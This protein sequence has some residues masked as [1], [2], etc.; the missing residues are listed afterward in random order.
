MD[1]HPIHIHGHAM[2]VVSTDGGEI[3]PSARFPETT[4]LVPVGT[5]RTIEFVADNPGDWPL[6]CH[7]THHAM[8]QMGHNVANMIGVDTHGLDA[9]IQR[10][11]PGYMTMG[12]DGMHEMSTMQMPPPENSISMVPGKGPHGIIEMGSMFTLLKVRK[13]LDGSGD[14]GWYDAPKDTVAAEATADELTRDGI[15]P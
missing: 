15:T 4:V 5:T 14:P 11:A 10:H 3:P 6:H 1:H 13:N 12:T 7:M 8:N 9:Q 2:T